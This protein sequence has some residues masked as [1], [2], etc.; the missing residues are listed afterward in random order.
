MG[1]QRSWRLILEEAV[2]DPKEKKRIAGECGITSRTLDRW[3][4]GATK[5]QNPVT[6]RNLSRAIPSVVQTEMF[7]ALKD[8]FPDAFLPEQ[9]LVSIVGE[10]PREFYSR[11]LRAY[12]T[13]PVSLRQWTIQNLVLG[14]LTYQLDPTKVGIGV[15]FVQYLS[16]GDCCVHENGEGT[17]LW[18]TRQALAGHVLDKTSYVAEAIRAAHA[19]FFQTF[20]SHGLQPPDFFLYKERIQSLAICPVRRMDAIAGGLVICS[21]QEDFFIPLRKALMD[22]YT[23]L[24]GLAFSDQD[25]FMVSSRKETYG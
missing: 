6:M 4:Q 24:F 17:G 12:T 7:E 10:V 18:Q 8:E 1:T 20:S 13:I 19:R 21:V 2:E 22:E 11:V 9:P 23:H 5:P 25:F 15:V 16:T 3:I 14:Q